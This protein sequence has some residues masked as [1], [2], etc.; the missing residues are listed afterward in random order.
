M[1]VDKT[2][3]MHFIDL[4]KTTYDARAI[5]PRGIDARSTREAC[6]L[7][8]WLRGFGIMMGIPY[9]AGVDHTGFDSLTVEVPRVNIEYLKQEQT[10][11]F[12]RPC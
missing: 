4:F 11:M 5:D 1:T 7:D 10:S 9:Q 8:P 2:Y 6:I 3:V 12:L